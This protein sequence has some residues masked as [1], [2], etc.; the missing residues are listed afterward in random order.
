MLVM[1]KELDAVPQVPASLD[2]WIFFYRVKPLSVLG[3]PSLQFQVLS[4]FPG[5]VTHFSCAEFG[6]EVALVGNQHSLCVLTVA[7]ILQDFFWEAYGHSWWK[8]L[9]T[10]GCTKCWG[11]G[12]SE[13]WGSLGEVTT[14]HVILSCF[15]KKQIGLS[16]VQLGLMV[17]WQDLVFPVQSV[18]LVSPGLFCLSPLK[19]PS[20]HIYMPS[21][22][23]P[24]TGWQ[25][26]S[27]SLLILILGLPGQLQG[28]W[29]W[30]EYL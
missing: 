28:F 11:L 3:T 2:T 14:V 5:A 9:W 12:M 22:S 7:W 29:L 25:P 20:D 24:Q 15:S 23:S 8:K 18:L 16:F 19:T 13:Q 1:H 21:F 30:Q 17:Y 6:N 27:S 4:S 26:K 10:Q